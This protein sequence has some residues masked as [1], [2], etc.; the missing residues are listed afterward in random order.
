MDGKTIQM[1]AQ[2]LPCDATYKRKHA[3]AEVEGW[4]DN[5][6]N[7]LWRYSQLE[8]GWTTA[9]TLA[10]YRM[11]FPGPVYGKDGWVFRAYLMCLDG[12]RN[13]DP[14]VAEAYALHMLEPKFNAPREKLKALLTAISTK[15]TSARHILAVARVTGIPP[16]T[17]EAFETLFYNLLD[18]RDEAGML[19]SETMY[20]NTRLVE[21]RQDYIDTSPMTDIV[22]RAGYNTGELDLAS[23]LAGFGTSAYLDSDHSRDIEDEITK[24]IIANGMLWA[25]ANLLNQSTPG[26]SRTTALLTA[27][28]QGGGGVTVPPSVDLDDEYMMNL[29]MDTRVINERVNAIRIANASASMV[30][31]DV[32]SK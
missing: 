13:Y 31:L 19:M 26:M 12:K 27:K 20:P 29:G 2:A 7:F 9:E 32:E 24:R 6:V 15:E 14:H 25:R 11:P 1:L 18:R 22:R 10:R 3:Y 17:V 4:P 23:F 21:L 8:F 16:E 28:R 30:T 5:A